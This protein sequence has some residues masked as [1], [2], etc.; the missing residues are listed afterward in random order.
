M[1]I[2]KEVLEE[3]DQDKDPQEENKEL[4]VWQY[5]KEDQGET[6]SPEEEKL[7]KGMR[8]ILTNTAKPIRY[9]L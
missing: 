6:T 5:L 8:Q 2:K 7:A 4:Q 9:S 1:V 3:S